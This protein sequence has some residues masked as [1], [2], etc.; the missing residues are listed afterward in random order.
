MKKIILSILMLLPM[1]ADAYNAKV[2]DIYYNLIAKAGTAEV[3]FGDEKY[4]GDVVI[5]ASFEYEG[6]QYT[7]SVISEDAFKE[8]IDLHSVVFTNSIKTIG[9]RAFRGCV[10]VES[11]TWSDGIIEIG[12]EAFYNCAMLDKIE[13]PNSVESIGDYSFY[14]CVSAKTITIGSGLTSIGESVFRDCFA[15]SEIVI[16]DGVETVGIGAFSGCTTLSSVRIGNGVKYILSDAFNGCLGI[17]SLSIPANIK[18][19]GSGAFKNC[20]NLKSVHIT[21]LA[22]WCNINF[23]DIYAN[24]LRYAKHLYLNGTEFDNLI[25]PDDIKSISLGAF[26]GCA[27]IKSVTFP[28]DFEIIGQHAFQECTGLIEVNIPSRTKVIGNYAF[29]GCSNLRTVSVKSHIRTS[30]LSG[31]GY[32]IY[33]DFI[34]DYNTSIASHAFQNCISLTTINIGNTVNRIENEA[35][36]DCKNLEDVFCYGNLV[37]QTDIDVFKNSYVEYAK[38]HVRGN[39]DDYQGYDPWSKFGSIVVND[40]KVSNLDCKYDIEIGGIYYDVYSY[41]HPLYGTNI[42][43]ASV[44]YGDKYYSGNV[45][46]PETIEYDGKTY[47]V[48]MIDGAAFQESKLLKSV[49]IPK[50]VTSI[51]GGAFSFCEA[52]ETVNIP[53]GVTTIGST[54]FFDCRSLKDIELPDNL[55][56]IES[57]AF[58]NC[59]SLSSLKLGD[60]VTN[61]TNGAFNGCSS[62]EKVWLGSGLERIGIWSFSGCNSLTDVYC[63]AEIAPEPFSTYD[64][65]FDEA[66]TSTATLHVL[67]QSKP[68]YSTKKPWMDFKNVVA[69]TDEDTGIY[70]I[71]SNQN[72]AIASSSNA[73]IVTGMGSGTM[74]S[75]CDISGRLFYSAVSDGESVRIETQLPKGS[76]VIVKV[77]N[78]TAKIKL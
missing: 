2:G 60:K 22:T 67:E 5:P 20:D 28:L 61:I 3:T 69:L 58:Y 16:P 21:D 18:E 74:V 39:I 49:F 46:I 41:F 6:K 72:V 51:G 70:I 38:L 17:E 13:I 35:F 71:G 33:D 56:S 14:G 50:G 32:D 77:G 63:F 76:M 57:S 47:D 52:L 15:F 40:S 68:S 9:N 73:I 64:P 62:L 75:V 31:S 27:S 54:T 55:T 19:V 42:E 29:E 78:S 34:Y 30:R 26:Y 23:G 43:G 7:V 59:H 53:Q 10:N 37:P 24:P 12:R 8:C 65:I 11:V 4:S 48:K 66:T 45:V 36:S 25:I 1:I 44:T